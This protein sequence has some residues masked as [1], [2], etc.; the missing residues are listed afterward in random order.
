MNMLDDTVEEMLE[1]GEIIPQEKLESALFFLS[2]LDA[3]TQILEVKKLQRVL[4]A[5]QQSR[6]M[7]L[8][9]GASEEDAL[10]QMRLTIKKK[11]EQN[12]S[13]STC[14]SGCSAHQH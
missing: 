11:L 2:V 5:A 13:P 6:S 8:Q 7:A 9:L 1:K 3:E 12:D 14:P 4:D 10:K